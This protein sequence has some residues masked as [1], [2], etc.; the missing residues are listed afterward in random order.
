MKFLS[1]ELENK[2]RV[3]KRG[4]RRGFGSVVGFLTNQFDERVI[5]SFLGRGDVK[6]LILNSLGKKPMHGYEI[7]SDVE[8]DFQGLYAPSPGA[9]YPTLQM[10]EEAGFVKCEESDGKKVYTLTKLG[11]DELLANSARVK[12]ILSRVSEHKELHW[13]GSAMR[14]LSGKYASLGSEVFL[15][16]RKHYHSGDGKVEVK[17]RSI[18][19]ILDDARK[20][21]SE[22]WTS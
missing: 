8:R 2:F 12:E 20:S 17:L 11:E 6:Y 10:L 19:K 14:S 21:V 15:A 5:E 13:F 22:V 4:F 1:E 18:E 3:G 7:I 16:A 9:V